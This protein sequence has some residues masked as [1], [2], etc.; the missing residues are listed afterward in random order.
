[1][2]PRH[3]RY[4][5]GRRHGTLSLDFTWDAIRRDSVVV[6]TAS[7]GHPP[8]TTNAPERFV[9]AAPFIVMNVAPRDGGVVFGVRIEWDEPIGLWTD[10]TVFDS[11]DSLYQ[12]PSRYLDLQ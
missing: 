8:I 4:Y 11:G 3:A 10:I 9:A 6:I 5:W 2:T 7:E 1:M 12:P